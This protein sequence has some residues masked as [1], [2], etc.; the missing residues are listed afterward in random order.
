MSSVKLEDVRHSLFHRPQRCRLEADRSAVT[1]RTCRRSTSLNQPSSCTE[2]H[3]LYVAHWLPMAPPAARVSAVGTVYHYFRNW[4]NAGVWA[5]LRRT[6]YKRVRKH[7]GRS[8]CPSVVIM[9]GQS[10]KTTE[11]GG[12]RGF[13]A[14]K[15]VKGRKR[16]ILVDTLGI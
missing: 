13:D 14:H 6:M 5:R 16:H 12:V 11:R 4:K 15:R 7:A 8:A 9:D 1:S 10:V 3:L 2:R